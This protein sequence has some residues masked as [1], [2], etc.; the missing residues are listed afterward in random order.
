MADV[1]AISEA[2]RGSDISGRDKIPAS[3]R[4]LPSSGTMTHAASTSRADMTVIVSLRDACA[5][6]ALGEAMSNATGLDTNSADDPIQRILQHSGNSMGVLGGT[7]QYPVRVLEGVAKANHRRGF[8]SFQVWIEVRTFI[9]PA[10]D[11]N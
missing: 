6:V 11:R 1:N 9:E 2:R 8:D 10:I 7:D 3:S 4:S 5:Y